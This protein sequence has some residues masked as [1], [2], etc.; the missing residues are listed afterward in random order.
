MQKAF[1]TFALTLED[2]VLC[3]VA[4]GT[5]LVAI[6][7]AKPVFRAIDAPAPRRPRVG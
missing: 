6:E 7:I 1:G 3:T 4:A 5:V 2:W